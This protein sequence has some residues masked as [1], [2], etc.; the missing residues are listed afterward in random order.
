MHELFARTVSYTCEV[1]SDAESDDEFGDDE[2]HVVVSDVFG[3]AASRLFARTVSYICEVRF[4]RGVNYDLAKLMSGDTQECC[5]TEWLAL[6][7][8]SAQKLQYV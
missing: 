6:W 2:F 3:K 7:M 4:E 5:E 1:R 8:Y